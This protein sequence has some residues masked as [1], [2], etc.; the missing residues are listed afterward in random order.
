MNLALKTTNA[1][2]SRVLVKSVRVC[3]VILPTSRLWK[4]VPMEPVLF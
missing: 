2:I 4:L 3:A 1:K